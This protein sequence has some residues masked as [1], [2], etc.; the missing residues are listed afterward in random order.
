MMINNT[1]QPIQ[2]TS[3]LFILKIIFATFCMFLGFFGVFVSFWRSNNYSVAPCVVLEIVCVIL[4]NVNATYKRGKLFDVYSRT[5]LQIIFILTCIVCALS[6]VSSIF[7]LQNGIRRKQDFHIDYDGYY[8]AALPSGLAVL[9]SVLLIFDSRIVRKSC[10]EHR[11]V[12]V[13]DP[14]NGDITHIV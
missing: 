8:F 10:F 9:N 1:A 13:I 14:D 2:P 3:G 6:L 5:K 12:Y 4:I 7:F 11:K